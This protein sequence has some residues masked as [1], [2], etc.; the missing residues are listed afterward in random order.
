MT[1][2]GRKDAWNKFPTDPYEPETTTLPQP[3]VMK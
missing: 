1:T 2:T 3:T